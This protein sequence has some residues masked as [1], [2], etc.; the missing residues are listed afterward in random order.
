MSD[1]VTYR[2]EDAVATI[3]M[4]DGKVNVM[5]TAMLRALDAALDRAQGD[6][7]IMVLRSAR[8][9]IFSAG[10]DLKIFAANDAERSL[11]MV[12]TGAEL[13]LRLLSYPFP[14]IG[15][16]EGHAYPMGTF[17]LLACDVRIGTAGTSRMGLNE[18]AIGISPP[19]F[20]IELVRSRVHPAWLSRTVTLGEMFE[21][22]EALVAG[23]LDRV[24]PAD[25]LEP[26]LKDVVA[27]LRKL[28]M[29]SHALAKQR[30]RH[31]A[32]A[33]MREAIDRELTLDAYRAG[34]ASHV[35]LPR[36]N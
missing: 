14:T 12:K 32:M 18:V 34:A 29:P 28:H 20:A 5:S 11:E 15:L 35:V 21:P 16:M 6:K 30:L 4:D 24:I 8:M 23:F 22:D 19:S 3:T 1:L 31:S 13:A 33:A 10:F 9:G 2:L 25:E 17:L 26:A 36:G 27:G 7:A